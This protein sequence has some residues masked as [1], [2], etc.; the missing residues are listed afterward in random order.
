[1]I[2]WEV[3]TAIDF[4]SDRLK[5]VEKNTELLKLYALCMKIYSQA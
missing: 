2:D 3:S 5:L 4:D 1:M